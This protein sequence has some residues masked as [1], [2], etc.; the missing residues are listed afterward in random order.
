MSGEPEHVEV[1]RVDKEREVRK[2]QRVTILQR[3]Y[4]A[5]FPLIGGLALDL[6]DFAT[7]GP[8]GLYAGFLTGAI[9][10]WLISSIYDFS[11]R[12]RLIWTVL[13]GIYCMIPMTEFVPLATMISAMARFSKTPPGR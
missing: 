13:G 2:L 5:F 10:G 4:K 9:V 6:A 11:P 12:T 1:K 3:L 8:I 7:L